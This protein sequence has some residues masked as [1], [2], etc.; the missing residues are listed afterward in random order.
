[1][2]RRLTATA[3]ALSATALIMGISPAS[4]TPTDPT[5]PVTDPA[6]SAEAAAPAAP[7]TPSTITLPLFGAPLT[8][9]IT[10]GPGGV[11]ASVAVNPADGLTATTLKPNRVVFVNEEG[12]AKVVVNARGG[13]QKIEARAGSLAEVSGPGGWSGDLF[14]TG[15]ITTVGFEIVALADGS[16]DIANITTSDPTAEIGTVEHETDDDGDGDQ[17]AKV[18][19]RFTDGTQSRTLSIKVEAE[20]DRDGATEAKVKL[21]LSNVKGVS[22][23]AAEVAGAHSW[24][25]VLCDGTAAQIDYTVAEDGSLSAVSASPEPERMHVNGSKIQVRFTRHERVHIRVR[26]DDGELKISIDEKIRCHDAPPPSVNTEVAPDAIRPDDDN[27][28][29][30]RDRDRDGSNDG[31]HRGGEGRG[32]NRSG[33]DRDD[34]RG[35]D[36]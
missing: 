27:D 1:M 33:G 22:L 29:R 9:D 30:D 35:G 23:P 20:V 21:A 7:A 15:A 34:H 24:N 18:R 28:R 8:V 17:E 31:G 6:A 13:N 32:G 2:Q 26:G 19:I 16:P 4:A 25:G 10:S 12:T 5:I 11:L 14:G 36:D 3:V